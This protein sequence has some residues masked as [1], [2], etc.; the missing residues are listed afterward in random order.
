MRARTF[1]STKRAPGMEEVEITLTPNSNSKLQKNFQSR[2]V[3][4]LWS[5]EFEVWS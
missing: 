1:G 4:S 5:L 3:D 2:G